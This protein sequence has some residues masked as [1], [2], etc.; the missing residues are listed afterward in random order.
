MHE[1]TKITVAFLVIGVF[2][3]S[4]AS[5]ENIYTTARFRRLAQAIPSSYTVW[6]DGSTYR[7]ESNI[8]GGSDF[9][10]T[11][12]ATVIESAI[13]ALG[14]S[15]G[16]IFIRAGEY[17]CASTTIDAIS[18]LDYICLEGEGW[19]WVSPDGSAGTGMTKLYWTG[20]VDGIKI[21]NT[22]SKGMGISL[23]NLYLQGPGA[24]TSTA[25]GVATRWND[26]IHIIDCSVVGFKYGYYLTEEDAL[27]MRG[28][29]SLYNQYGLYMI[30]DFY[31]K[32]TDCEISDNTN[33]QLYIDGGHNNRI[34]GCTFKANAA[35]I[36]TNINQPIGN[37]SKIRDSVAILTGPIYK[38]W[39]NG[40]I[41]TFNGDGATVDFTWAHSLVATPNALTATSRSTDAKGEF[42]VTA[43]ATN[44]IA[45][46]TVA[47][48]LG[49]GNVILSWY[50][51]E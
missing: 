41:A 28:C 11:N 1:Q 27:H 50:A 44:I 23:V 7:A 36:Y 38:Y 40:G 6:K 5:G 21:W 45:H 34:H 15:G 13:T 48:I 46:F 47:P 31:G 24:G 12:P 32:V 30:N 42:Y 8:S 18:E 43:D 20:D 9:S 37:Y 22:G 39:E 26:Q 33:T 10:G 29:S 16:K 17:P 51:E 49:V 3:M 35:T 19:G 25:S 14:S 4:F 2:I